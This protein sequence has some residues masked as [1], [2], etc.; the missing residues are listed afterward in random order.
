LLETEER[1]ITIK[2]TDLDLAITTF[3]EAEINQPGAIC[4]QARKLFEIVK[5]LP[6]AD[7][8]VKCVEQDQVVITCE[9]SRFRLIGLSKESFPTIDHCNV[10]LVSLPT[11]LLSTFIGR[12]LFAITNE[13]SRY[14]LNGAKLEL[15]NESIRMVTTDG[16]RLSFIE[17]RERFFDGEKVDVLVPRKTLSELARLCNESDGSV[18]FGKS[19]YFLELGIVC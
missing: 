19:V 10:I 3:C 16:H 8:E 1:G 11:T 13:E 9:R 14:S 15:S 2:G 4:V 7:I 6:E 17:K 18:E 5:S 12:T